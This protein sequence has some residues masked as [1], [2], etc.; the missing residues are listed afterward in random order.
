MDTPQGWDRFELRMCDRAL[1]YGRQVV[2]VQKLC[3][4][5]E[6]RLNE[7]GRRWDE[8]GVAGIVA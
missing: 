8:L 1:N 3:E 7:L 2:T 5:D 6:Q 4:V